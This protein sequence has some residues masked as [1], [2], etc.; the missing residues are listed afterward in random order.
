[1]GQIKI[2]RKMTLFF[3]TKATRTSFAVPSLDIF[4]SVGRQ[5]ISFHPHIV[6]R[7]VV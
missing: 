2:K 1:M 3:G 4:G 6:V 7:T 5:Q